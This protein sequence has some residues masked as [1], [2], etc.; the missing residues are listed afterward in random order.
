VLARVTLALPLDKTLF[1]LIRDAT[2]LP[3]QAALVL[4][5]KG[6]VV[7]GGPIGST[8]IVEHGRVVFGSTSFNATAAPL[9][10]GGA[11]V[12]AIEPVSAVEARGVSYRRRL[13]IAAVLTLALVAG[14]A[15]RLGRPLARMFGE[16]ADQAE[17]DSL[18]GLA[19]RRVLDERLEEE[20]DRSRRY[21]AKRD[22]KDRV[23]VDGGGFVAGAREPTVVKPA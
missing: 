2:P 6:R 10:V 20:L 7:A 15:T 19:N 12:L 21:Q 22:G 1:A 18:T 23:V 5:R 9:G 17:R 4:V 13:L 14:L 8:A 3:S 16:L 11:S